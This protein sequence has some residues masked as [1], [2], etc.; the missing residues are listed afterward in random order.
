[1]AENIV[2]KLKVEL[3]LNY[4]KFTQ[5]MGKVN[6]SIGK[7]DEEFEELEKAS[8]D[9]AEEMDKLGDKVKTVSDKLKQQ[10]Q[11]ADKASDGLDK[12]KD[13]ADKLKGGFDGVKDAMGKVSQVL[14]MFGIS[15]GI[16]ELISQIK[17]LNQ[18]A[19]DAGATFDDLYSKIYF[20][21]GGLS[22]GQQDIADELYAVYGKDFK[23]AIANAL[24]GLSTFFPDATEDQ[25]KSITETLVV[26][27]KRGFG[28]T[29][30][31]VNDLNDLMKKY[32]V[33]VADAN[34]L[35]DYLS[36]TSMDT[37]E[38]VTNLMARIS[39]ADEMAKDL[40]KDGKLGLDNVKQMA[41]F[42]GN[43]KFSGN[44]GDV[45][46]IPTMYETQRNRKI[47]ELQA[48]YRENGYAGQAVSEKDA[49]IL[50]NREANKIFTTANDMASK[51]KSQAEASQIWANALG[52]EVGKVTNMFA[53]FSMAVSNTASNV[54]RQKVSSGESLVK[55]SGQ[56][57]SAEDI[58]AQKDATF[59]LQM[60]ESAATQIDKYATAMEKYLSEESGNWMLGW[61]ESASYRID[62]TIHSFFDDIL[63]DLYDYDISPDKYMKTRSFTGYELYNTYDMDENSEAYEEY[64]TAIEN[65]NTQYDNLVETSE[66][67]T[68]QTTNSTVPAMQT[69]SDYANKLADSWKNA[70]EA[71]KKYQEL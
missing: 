23:D 68:E 38:T 52:V 66:T 27:Q 16:A 26:M 42:F 14:G 11:A 12:T 2:D 63:G 10:E 47:A 8:S 20:S 70:Y 30:S 34:T 3:E 35:L 32:N 25:L 62:S 40:A 65:I 9:T 36:A 28:D 71:K 4:A 1:M 22:A 48:T 5:Q 15:V 37:G 60:R 24:G 29:A 67:Y 57:L 54:Q 6:D 53:D 46:G 44:A 59:D 45:A 51:A 41:D 58:K 19:V 39:D 18:K 43:A 31:L 21:S 69:E 64:R 50:A 61:A 13:K 49:A 55:Q 56:F 33:Y 17:E 7:T